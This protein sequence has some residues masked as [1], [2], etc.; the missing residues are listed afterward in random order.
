M[1]LFVINNLFTEYAYLN[2]DYYL[3]EPAESSNAPCNRDLAKF[4]QQ[5]VITSDSDDDDDDD[6][7]LHGNRR[8]T[9][10]AAGQSS[11]TVTSSATA[12]SGSFSPPTLREFLHATACENHPLSTGK[13]LLV[14]SLVCGRW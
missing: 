5:L 14:S 9:T 1:L 2:H 4:R 13:S 12:T 10:T 6:D 7:N 8:T 3:L 11:N